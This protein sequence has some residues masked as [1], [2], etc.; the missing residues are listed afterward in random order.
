MLAKA[1]VE[2]KG[3]GDVKSV[4][5]RLLAQGEHFCDSHLFKFDRLVELSDEHIEHGSINRV[6]VPKDAVAKVV[7]DKKTRLLGEG[8]HL[9]ESP[10]FKFKGFESII[11]NSCIVHGT[12]TIVRVSLGQIALAWMNNDPV[13]IDVPGLYEYDSPGKLKLICH[14]F[15]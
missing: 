4:S 13:F 1:W 12:I 9:I 14:L 3:D 15:C 2:V 7:H 8:D 5:P 10:Q 11:G 6:S